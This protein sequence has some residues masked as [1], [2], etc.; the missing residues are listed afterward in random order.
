MSNNQ[1]KIVITFQP[2]GKRVNVPKNSTILSAA[3]L[4]GVD[5]TSICNG[6]GNCGKCKVIIN[7]KLG[8]N[9]VT[10]EER[11]ILSPNDIMSNIRLACCTKAEENTVVKIPE[12]SRTGK[13]RLQVEGIETPISIFPSIKKF[14]LEINEP[15]LDDL[16]SDIDRVIHNLGTKYG[17]SGVSVNFDVVKNFAEKVRECDWKITIVLYNNEIIDIESGDTTKKIYG[18]AVDIGTTKLAGYLLNLN[19][20]Q[21]IA[22]D[23]LMNPQIPYGEDV[24][25]RLNYPDQKKLQDAVVAGL[26][27]ILEKLK[28]KSGINSEN[29]YEMTTVGNTVMHHIFL[30]INPLFLGRSPYPPVIRNLLEVHAKEIGIKINTKGKIIFLPVIAGFVGADAIGVILASKMHERNEICLAIDIGTNTE[31]ILGN[32]DKLLAA[33]CA[34]GPAFE[35]AHIKFGMRA[36]SGSIEKINIEPKTFEIKYETIDNANPIGI[37]G[38]GMIDLV[39][40]MLRVGI[41]DV[42]GIIKRDLNNP[43]IRMNENSVMEYLIVPASESGNNQDITFSQQDVN[44]IILAKAA[45]HTG[46]KLLLKNYPLEMKSIEIVFLAGAFGSHINKESART[47]GLLPEFDINKIQVIG[48][49]AGTGSRIALVSDREKTTSERIS[50][51]V[52]YLEIGNDKNFQNTFLNS[53]IIP[54]ADLTEFPETSNLLKK[55]NNYPKIPPPKF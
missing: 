14:Y 26:N 19:T 15:T 51:K 46:I 28:E 52:E 41:I 1:S 34:S 37:C 8:L 5:L 29:I 38:S 43:R 36:A 30:G 35:G 2:E 9:E 40:E 20:G 27:Q 42:G 45:I 10:K 7:D 13:Q 25:T 33:S 31:V 55:N 17:I 18:Y 11:E 23:S 53:H 4:A 54:Y 24:I 6:K 49:A 22:A 3:L 47:I 44:Q 32:K 50:E 16:E 12:I 39:A 21:V 48:N